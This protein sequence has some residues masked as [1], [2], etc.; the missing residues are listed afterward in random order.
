M[1]LS[2]IAKPRRGGLGPLGLSS[3]GKKEVVRNLVTVDRDLTTRLRH[4]INN[5]A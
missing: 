3:H 2:V 4:F 5:Y 1:C